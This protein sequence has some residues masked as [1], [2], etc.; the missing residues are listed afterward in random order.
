MKGWKD[1]SI[2]VVFCSVYMA[3]GNHFYFFH[4]YH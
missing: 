3:I 2:S 1:V 4:R